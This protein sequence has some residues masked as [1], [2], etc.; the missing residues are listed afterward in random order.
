MSQVDAKSTGHLGARPPKLL[1]RPRIKQVQ[2]RQYLL[3][4]NISPIQTGSRNGRV[5]PKGAPG[6]HPR[7]HHSASTGPHIA[8]AAQ[9]RKPLMGAPWGAAIGQ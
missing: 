4:S 6:E 1:R 7:A 3:Y 8:P 5:W 9:T 2:Y